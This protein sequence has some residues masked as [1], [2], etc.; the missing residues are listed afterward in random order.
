MLE[1]KQNLWLLRRSRPMRN[2]FSSGNTDS[3]EKCHPWVRSSSNSMLHF[4]WL[5]IMIGS[6]S[7]FNEQSAWW[8]GL[9]LSGEWQHHHSHTA[10]HL[11]GW[12]QEHTPSVRAIVLLVVVMQGEAL[13]LTHSPYVKPSLMVL[14][15]LSPKCR[16]WTS[17]IGIRSKPWKTSPLLC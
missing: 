11:V 14:W 2:W 9:N 8:K 7:H 1:V 3:F 13:L 4:S 15:L 16:P 12:E 10:L 6:F 17:A 5:K